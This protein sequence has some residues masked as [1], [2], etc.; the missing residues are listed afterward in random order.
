VTP[1][2]GICSLSRDGCKCEASTAWDVEFIRH[3][4]RGSTEFS[5]EMR[6]Q[7]TSL[8]FSSHV[9]FKTFRD[10]LFG[11]IP[12]SGSNC[13]KTEQ[14][15]SSP[16]KLSS[17]SKFYAVQLFKYSAVSLPKVKARTSNNIDQRLLG[18]KEVPEKVGVVK[19]SPSR[20]VMRGSYLHS[21][22]KLVFLHEP[23]AILDPA[24][25]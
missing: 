8:C 22:A 3:P 12:R 10:I 5:Q 2:S 16:Q 14:R 18:D 23:P 25:R 19:P 11:I 13:Q 15:I 20:P 7:Q 4:F 24:T 6:G 1:A 9:S 21:P 17:E